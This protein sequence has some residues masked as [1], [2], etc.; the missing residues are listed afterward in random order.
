MVCPTSVR[1]VIS[2][3][4][5][6]R[7]SPG[8][9]VFPQLGISRQVWYVNQK[10]CVGEAVKEYGAVGEDSWAPSSGRIASEGYLPGQGAFSEGHGVAY[11]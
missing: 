11:L 8:Q 10:V 2:E 5:S 4:S 7:S 9:G 6:R 3:V 1:Y